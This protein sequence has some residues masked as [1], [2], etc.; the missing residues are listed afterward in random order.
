M[1]SFKQLIKNTNTNSNS[2]EKLNLA[3]LS[4]QSSQFLSKLIHKTGL[5]SDLNIFVWEAPID[6]IEQQISNPSSEFNNSTF[7]TSIVF[8]SSHALLK[9]YNFSNSNDDFALVQFDRIKNYLDCSMNL[10]SS[11]IILFNLSFT[12]KVGTGE[13]TELFRFCYRFAHRSV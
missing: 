5:D 1:K 7:H 12:T 10:S 13:R 6:Q 2:F 9:K 11:K 8:E 3:L 4:D